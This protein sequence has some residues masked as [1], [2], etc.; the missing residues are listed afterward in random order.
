M[1]ATLADPI[2]PIFMPM[3]VGYYLRLRGVFDVA[4]AQAINRF[5]FFV[6]I[7]ALMFS[8]I[9]RVPL[10]EIDLGAIGA[11]LAAELLVYGGVAVAAHR[12]FRRPPAEAILSG[13]AAAFANHVLFVLPIAQNL[14]GAAAV[15]PITAI[16]VADSLI[17]CATVFAVDLIRSHRADAPGQYG[18][19]A[20]LRMLAKNPFL[21]ATVL[22]L[23][24]AGLAVPIPTGV[25][26]YPRFAG[27]AAAP[28]SLFALGVILA[29]QTL[30][31]IG[32]PAGLIVATK[33]LVHPVLVLLLG[34]L[35]AARPDWHRMAVL[36]AAGPCGAM[37]FVIALQ[38]SV[39]PETIAK[40]VLISTVLS[41][42]SLS[43][44][45][46]LHG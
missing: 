15:Q 35:L 12:L 4:A 2:L 3:V 14:Y 44:L 10:G 22:G 41:L 42:L 21:I 19:L 17:F 5:V 6:A 23:A 31:P 28:V 45:I 27:A 38:F 25:F 37:P 24:A 16:I 33:L 18:A 32:A 1:L 26:T 8:L 20:V 29:G 7:P 36:V 46:A 30:R 11:Y 34:G 40:A 13:M 9:A 39:R 43:F